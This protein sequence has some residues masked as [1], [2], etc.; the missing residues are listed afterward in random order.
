MSIRQILWKVPCAIALVAG[1][2]LAWGIARA[3]IIVDATITPMGGG[4]FHY[5]ISITNNEAE[6]VVLVTITDAPL[7]DPL[8]DPTLTVPA[9]FLGNYDD[10]LGFVDFI[11]DTVDFTVGSTISGF[12]FDSLGSPPT[13][14]TQFQALS[15]NGT[16]FEGDITST[17]VQVP[18]P[19]G[20]ALLAL[21][22][23]I[24]WCA[25]IRGIPGPVRF[26]GSHR[27]ENGGRCRD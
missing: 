7:A 2:T 18:E 6:D 21:G 19:A 20:L 26:G 25:V 16:Q 9:G 12:S 24:L 3:A 22:L 5:E 14:F 13:Y 17:V 27:I 15:V 8:I 1:T 23:A 10:G 4:V 11:A